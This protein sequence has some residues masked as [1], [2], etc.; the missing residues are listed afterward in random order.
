M[1]AT[2]SHPAYYLE[3][4]QRLGRQPAE[5]LMVG[6]DWR[7]DIVSAAAAGMQV[8]WIANPEVSQPDA[9]LVLAGRG[10]LGDLLGPFMI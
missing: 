1:H 9:G 8:Y 10:R 5:C 2:K 7:L 4:A 6:D 3:I